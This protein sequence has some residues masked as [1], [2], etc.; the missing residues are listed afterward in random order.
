M[1]FHI[2]RMINDLSK[3]NK[4]IFYMITIVMSRAVTADINYSR[5]STKI[6]VP[7]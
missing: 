1:Y 3:K 6:I 2:V 7:S 5:P 4:T